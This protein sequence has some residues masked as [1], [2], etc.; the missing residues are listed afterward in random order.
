MF[1]KTLMSTLIVLSFSAYAA[2]DNSSK[3]ANDYDCTINE[4]QSYMGK[5]TESMTQRETA[6]APFDDFQKGNV[7]RTSSANAGGAAAAEKNPDGTP[8]EECNYFWGDLEDIKYEKKD[9]SG[10]LDAILSGDIGGL[11]N[12]SKE[13]V[14]EVATGMTDEIKKGV[15][16]RLSTENVKKTVIDYGD[17]ALKGSTGYDTGDITDPDLNGFVNDGLKG[18]FGNTGKLINVF[19]PAQDKNRAN[20]ILKETDRQAKE[21]MKMD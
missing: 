10:I 18:G 5:K 1:K 15:C 2:T 11:V 4:L 3:V 20:V 19:D 21:M 14:M 16:K 17:D 6:I 13:R 8:K 12:A 9:D 7:A